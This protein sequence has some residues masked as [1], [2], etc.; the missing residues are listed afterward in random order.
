V[1]SPLRT[2]TDADADAIAAAL[3]R[4]LRDERE[5]DRA[6]RARRTAEE[7]AVT[8]IDRARARAIARKHGLLVRQ[9]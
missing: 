2:I 3:V 6:E 9:R 7:P 5:A 1:T 4:H 8:D